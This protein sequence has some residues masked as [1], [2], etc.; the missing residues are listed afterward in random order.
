M[1]I[2]TRINHQGNN[3]S[4]VA[5]DGSN[6]NEFIIDVFA[7]ESNVDQKI[8]MTLPTSSIEKITKQYLRICGQ[9]LYDA[10]QWTKDEIDSLSI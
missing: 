1:D 5:H 3:I 8:S 4:V 10:N 6:K 7:R 2:R 9:K